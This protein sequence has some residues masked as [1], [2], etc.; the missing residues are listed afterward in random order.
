[1]K[2]IFTALLIVALS[3]CSPAATPA[4]SLEDVFYKGEIAF[5]ISAPSVSEKPNEKA[6]TGD[7]CT[8]LVRAS[9][10]LKAFGAI[11]KLPVQIN[12]IDNESKRDFYYGFLSLCLSVPTAPNSQDFMYNDRECGDLVTQA[13]DNK[14]Y[15]Q[16]YATPAP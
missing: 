8:E 9:K 15:E 2:I 12:N 16:L 3:A 6:F 10:S 1:M 14:Y 7:E 11:S 5:C 4:P 13:V